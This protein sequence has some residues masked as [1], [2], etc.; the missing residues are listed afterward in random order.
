VGIVWQARELFPLTDEELEDLGQWEP[1]GA[2]PRGG[3]LLK[4]QVHT[5]RDE[6]RSSAHAHPDPWPGQEKL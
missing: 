2:T 5:E 6:D 3:L 4:R 1:I